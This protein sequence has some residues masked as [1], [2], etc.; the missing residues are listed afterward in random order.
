L[1]VEDDENSIWSLNLR[2]LQFNPRTLENYKLVPEAYSEILDRIK[3]EL[4]AELLYSYENLTL[5][6]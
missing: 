4:W 5:S 1:E 2:K 6:I 3:Y